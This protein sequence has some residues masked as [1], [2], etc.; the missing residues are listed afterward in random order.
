M[1]LVDSI[2]TRKDFENISTTGEEVLILKASETKCDCYDDRN[3][4][5]SEPDPYCKKC[6]GTG[7]Y[8]NKILS[9]KIRYAVDTKKT[10]S[11]NPN[12]YLKEK[13]IFYFNENY[14][15]LSNKDILCIFN[16]ERTSV[17]KMYRIV[18]KQKMQADDFVY[19]KIVGNKINYIQKIEV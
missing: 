9:N 3:L 14:S 4:I 7:V 19:Y 10:E 18:S 6:F 2:K 16:C 15:F 5:N 12:T 13:V 11:V 1:S 8:R 17:E